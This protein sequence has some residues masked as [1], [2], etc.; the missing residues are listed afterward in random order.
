MAA[1]V[2]TD[3]FVHEAAALTGFTK[4]M[5]DYL[6]SQEI[7]V[8]SGS[9][10]GRPG[11]RRRYTYADVVVLRALHQIC[12]SS[13]RIKHLRKALAKFHAEVGSIRPGMTLQ[14]RLI[15]EG[16]ELCLYSPQEGARILRTG[17]LT[18]GFFVVDMVQVTEEIASC[19]E[20]KRDGG[21]RLTE[22]AAAR[23][24]AARQRSWQRIQSWRSRSAGA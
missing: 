24:E 4:D 15:V 10:R 6:A 13:R 18:L 22:E 16:S 11:L 1:K 3:F 5:L 17:Q 14:K 9:P 21:I 23:A 7:F 8:H 20:L 19:V 2:K 12:S